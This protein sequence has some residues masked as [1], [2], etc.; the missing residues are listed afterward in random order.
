MVLC[1]LATAVIVLRSGLGNLSGVLQELSGTV[2]VPV[3]VLVALPKVPRNGSV[4]AFAVVGL[5]LG[6]SVLG[7]AVAESVSGITSAMVNLGTVPQSPADLPL[8]ASIGLTVAMSVWIPSFVLI[9]TLVLLLFPD[10][11]FPEPRRRW[12]WIG[13]ATIWT[14]TV[15]M[16]AVALQY[17]PTRTQSYNAIGNET[18][19][20][21]SV[22]GVANMLFVL[23][24]MVSIVG[25]VIK[26]KRAEGEDRL[27]YRWVGFAFFAFAVWSIANIFFGSSYGSVITDV[28]SW[29]MII[30]IPVS[31]TVAIL[32]YRLY[33]IDVV[34][35][36][37]LTYGVLAAFITGVYALL[38]VGLGSLISGSD[39]PNLALSIGAV[40]IV[41]VA[42]EPLRRR[43]QHWA[44]RL[45][46]GR[47]STPYEVLS[48]VTAG[49][50]RATDPDAALGSLTSM[51]VDG[52]GAVEAVAWIALGGA[53]QPRAAAPPEALATL[54][55]IQMDG[56]SAPDV[57][58]DRSVAVRHHDE[59]LGV[60]SIKKARG[61]SVTTAD[62][63]ML[64]DVAA[65]AGLLFR[66]IRLNAELAERADQLRASRRRLVAAQDTERHR[67]ERD[68]HD[69]AQQQVVALKVKLGIAATFA[70]REGAEDVAAI[71][72]D[73]SQTT[74]DAVDAMRAV[75]HGIYPPLL[76]AEGL[77]AALVA[78]K[79]TIAIPM[80]IVSLEVDRYDR[81][82]EESIYFAILGTINQAVDAGAKRAVVSL[83]STD[84]TVRF[85]VD[86]DARPS[87]LRQVEDRMAALDGT[88]TTA[89]SSNGWIITGLLPASIAAMGQV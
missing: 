76:E 16:V 86:V 25:Y 17:W 2:I 29:V 45:V 58:G 82:V 83:S 50:S 23:L 12:R 7:D 70:N 24:A 44:N 8:P 38:V 79:R 80:E 9:P 62:E 59:I 54:D 85:A 56:E 78:A 87:D 53:L 13:T 36:R 46:Y 51:V 72:A 69:G 57:P 77:N 39:E 73:V 30:A 61:E 64:A 74:Q 84:D 31:Y 32:K 67:L 4:W 26:W 52:V 19:V 35:S 41:A 55:V 27:Q 33:G 75:A 3:V 47:R 20:V 42:F 66:N 10:G 6:F 21:G 28:V 15:G 40:A 81:G 63:K 43:I 11:K 34:I 1:G 49:L 89:S 65:G 14:A 88:V 48:G 71:I 37:A 22:S 60:V 18:T 68:L 5:S